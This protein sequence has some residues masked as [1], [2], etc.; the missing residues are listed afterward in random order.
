[1]SINACGGNVVVDSGGP[2]GGGTCESVCA[3][4]PYTCSVGSEPTS[5]LTI[6]TAKADGCTAVLSAPGQQ[7]RAVDIT[8]SMNQGCIQPTPSPCGLPCMG[9]EQCPGLV[10]PPGPSFMLGALVCH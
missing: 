4:G 9:K 1:M 8:C 3:G 7:D 5:S 10:T 6:D 2:V